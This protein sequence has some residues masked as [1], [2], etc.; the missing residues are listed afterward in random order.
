MAKKKWLPLFIIGAILIMACAFAASRLL[1]DAKTVTG[2]VKKQK[3]TVQTTK[4]SQLVFAAMGDQLAHDSVVAQAK[5]GDTYDFTPYFKH[6]RGLYSNAD[7][8]FCNA[9]SLAAGQQLGISG[10]PTFNAPNEFARD[11]V[12]GAGCNLIGLANN[13][14]NDK[15][16]AGIDANLGVWD[17]LPILAH[18]GSNKSAEDQQNIPYFTKN[19]IKVAFLAYA[20]Y[21]N[22]TNLTSYGLNIYHDEQLFSSQLKEARANAD[23]VIVS[24]HWG[25]E[26]ST[27]PNSDQAAMAQRA[28]DLGAD[29]VIGTGPHVLQKTVWLNGANDKKTLVWYSIGNMLSS[30]L[31]INELTS[32][33]AGFTLVK[34]ATG[35]RVESPTFKATFMSYDW[36]AADRAAQRL[37]T[38]SNLKLQPLSEAT[39]RPEAMF[40]SKYS[41]SERTKYVHDTITSAAGVTFTP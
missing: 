37:T 28:A 25:T 5:S 12:N 34:E 26:D 10:Y 33:V 32:G 3:H 2:G 29:V 19:G 14:M 15:Q 35:V 27:T 22:N 20:D 16:Q 21:S 6:I 8:V 17:S 1:G 38:R 39:G 7:V 23:A 31:A 24:L 11:L 9:E 36:P 13:H 4:P 30:Q 18:S 41:V 40:G